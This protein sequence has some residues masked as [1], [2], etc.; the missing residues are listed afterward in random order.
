MA[1]LAFW[2]YAWGEPHLFRFSLTKRDLHQKKTPRQDN[3][4]ARLCLLLR[5]YDNYKYMTFIHHDLTVCYGRRALLPSGLRVNFL[6]LFMFLWI[7][8]LRYRRGAGEGGG[9]LILIGQGS[10]I[11]KFWSRGPFWTVLRSK[12]S[13][14]AVEWAADENKETAFDIV[15]PSVCPQ[16]NRMKAWP[17]IPPCLLSFS[18]RPTAKQPGK[19][20]KMCPDPH[21]CTRGEYRPNKTILL[22]LHS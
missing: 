3:L 6:A 5:C 12:P 1:G 7:Q 22:Q 20:E 16:T 11:W 15:C 9:F 2:L 18:Q 8:K 14:V 19:S 21:L 4:L 10:S 13:D 17:L